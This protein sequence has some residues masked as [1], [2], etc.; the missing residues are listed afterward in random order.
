[1]TKQ[2]PCDSRKILRKRKEI[3]MWQEP[4]GVFDR[5]GNRIEKFRTVVE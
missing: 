3:A 2:V 5:W 1:M 4:K